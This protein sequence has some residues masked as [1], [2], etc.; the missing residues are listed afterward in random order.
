MDSAALFA[1]LA[2][3]FHSAIFFVAVLVICQARKR[4][5]TLVFHGCSAAAACM[6]PV[7]VESCNDGARGSCGTE[8]F[9]QKVFKNLQLG[10]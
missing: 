8:I 9:S 10:V 6:P 7:D 5:K 2:I 1:M 3:I 4:D